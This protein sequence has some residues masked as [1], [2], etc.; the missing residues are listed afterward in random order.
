MN[1]KKLSFIGS[2]GVGKTTLIKLLT[3][4]VIPKTHNPTIG[5]D[6]DKLEFGGYNISLWE[7]GGQKQFQF[8][9]NDFIKGSNFI[10]VV[11]DSSENNIAETKKILDDFKLLRDKMLVIANQQDKN[12]ALTPTEIQERLGV[13]TIPMI[14]IDKSKKHDLLRIIEEKMN[15]V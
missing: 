6:F 3:E 4:Q 13:E 1:T 5:L 7:L 15:S 14:A 12:G 11:S 8:M 2:A 10:C 9:W